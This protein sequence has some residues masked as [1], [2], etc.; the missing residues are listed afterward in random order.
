MLLSSAPGEAGLGFHLETQ[1][2]EGEQRNNTSTTR[3]HQTR[4]ED[5]SR[6]NR[7][8]HLTPYQSTTL[9]QSSIIHIQG[10]PTGDQRGIGGAEAK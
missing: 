6:A 3:W 2:Q 7:L 8:T 1:E 5:F 4:W 10:K 9:T